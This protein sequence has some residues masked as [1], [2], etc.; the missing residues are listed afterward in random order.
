MKLC[1]N[2]GAFSNGKTKEG[3]LFVNTGNRDVNEALTEMFAL[4]A[5]GIKDP[6]NSGYKGGVSIMQYV[7][8]KLLDGRYKDA[9]FVSYFTRDPDFFKKAMEEGVECKGG[10]E[11][12]C[13]E[14]HTNMYHYTKQS[15]DN[16]ID[17]LR[18]KE[19]K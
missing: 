4:D 19:R 1:M 10:Y 6:G 3:Y 12:F 17:I 14:L 8:N 16:M 18:T 9:A 11:R 13:E 2:W 5:S 7:S 15:Y